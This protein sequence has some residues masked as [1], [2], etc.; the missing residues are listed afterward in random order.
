MRAA[1]L[2]MTGAKGA[3][4]L[5]GSLVAVMEARSVDIFVRGVGAWPGG[6]SRVV[7]WC[8]VGGENHD[9]HT[10]DRMTSGE[11]LV[12]ARND[13]RWSGCVA[14]GKSKTWNVMS[15]KDQMRFESSVSRSEGCRP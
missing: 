15:R 13:M 5:Q 1:T 7:I 14:G 11:V 10:V 3:L 8:R 9:R 4:G 2:R 6:K 12:L